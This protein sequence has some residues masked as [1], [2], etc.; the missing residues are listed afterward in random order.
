MEGR[1]TAKRGCGTVASAWQGRS[2]SLAWNGVNQVFVRL[3]LVQ[4]GITLFLSL[5]GFALF[6]CIAREWGC[7]STA[8]MWFVGPGVPGGDLVKVWGALLESLSAW[9]GTRHRITGLSTEYL[10]QATAVLSPSCHPRW[11]QTCQAITA[12]TGCIFGLNFLLLQ[13]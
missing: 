11:G 7:C 9:Q 12:L 4:G 3:Q 5:Q 2:P 13:F 8:W 6:Q 1:A 10:T